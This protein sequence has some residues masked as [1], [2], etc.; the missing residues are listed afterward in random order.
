[1]IHEFAVDPALVAAWYQRELG[2]FFAREFGVGTPRIISRFP[3][4]WKKRVWEE[5]RQSGSCSDLDE[6][7]M[8]AILKDISEKMVKRPSIDWDNSKS[9]LE[10]AESEDRL[11]PFHAIL[12]DENPRYHKRVLRS[13][14]IDHK[15]SVWHLPTQRRVPRNAHSLQEVAA[16]MLRIASKILFVDPH[17]DT[18]TRYVQPFAHYFKAI[19]DSRIGSRSAQASRT[20]LPSL[21]IHCAEKR[22]RGEFSEIAHILPQHLSIVIYTLKSLRGG[23]SLHNRYIL[24]DVGGLE[25]AHGLD[26]GTSPASDDRDDVLLLEQDIFRQLWDQY[27]NGAHAFTVVN[28]VRVKGN[29]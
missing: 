21:E 6:R 23:Q 8:T 12:S 19:M 2:R 13:Q 7:R 25:F 15:T 28:K 3:R 26:E 4:S 5:F 27:A 17:F 10:N 24:T 9:W 29:A 22:M 14:S 16:P 18:I 1:M 11:V 20:T